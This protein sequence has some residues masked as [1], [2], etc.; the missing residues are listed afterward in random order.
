MILYR[1]IGRTD[2]IQER[3]G[4]HPVGCTFKESYGDFGN[5]LNVF[6]GNERGVEGHPNVDLGGGIITSQE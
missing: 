4:K 2:F 1:K 3:I 6:Q 5:P